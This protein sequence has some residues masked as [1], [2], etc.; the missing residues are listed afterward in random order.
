MLHV[1][2]P[3]DSPSFLLNGGDHLTLGGNYKDDCIILNTNARWAIRSPNIA[4]FGSGRFFWEERLSSGKGGNLK[5][6]GR[7]F[8]KKPVVSA[9]P[10][11]ID[12]P[13][14]LL[15]GKKPSHR[16]REQ[17]QL[18]SLP[19]VIATAHLPYQS[20]VLQK[21]KF[22]MKSVFSRRENS[23]AAEGLEGVEKGLL[24]KLHKPLLCMKEAPRLLRIFF[25]EKG[26]L[27][28]GPRK[29]QFPDTGPHFRQ[30]ALCAC[31]KS[32]ITLLHN[33]GISAVTFNFFSGWILDPE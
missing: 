12:T 20:L 18:S 11:E 1:R 4:I 26:E 5:G 30:T 2:S 17:L 27:F 28:F 3:P 19:G 14:K 31:R 9:C 23:G 33:I 32:I 6:A 13:G 29:L 21:D 25:A 7:T 16:K 24:K 10:L 15:R 8:C 22:W